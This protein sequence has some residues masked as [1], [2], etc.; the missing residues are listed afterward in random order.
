MRSYKSK[1]GREVITTEEPLRPK[2]EQ[3]EIIS[4]NNIEQIQKL[5]AKE[6]AVAEAKRGKNG[7][8]K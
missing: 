2:S 6:K 5:R 8:K 4:T 3:S 1:K 7:N